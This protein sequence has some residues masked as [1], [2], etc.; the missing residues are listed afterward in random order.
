MQSS[1]KVL[2]SSVTEQ[3]QQKLYQQG[4]YNNSHMMGIDPKSTALAMAVAKLH[5]TDS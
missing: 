2:T 4:L 1:F 5:R 3:M